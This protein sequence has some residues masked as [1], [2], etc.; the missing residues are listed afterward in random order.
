MQK[1]YSA[2]LLFALTAFRAGELLEHGQAPLSPSLR[3]CGNFIEGIVVLEPFV[4]H[5]G[6]IDDYLMSQLRRAAVA[7][8]CE[9]TLLIVRRSA[10]YLE[11][12]QPSV[13]GHTD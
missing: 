12:M 6:P 13:Y 11:A 7:L 3:P 8:Y 10:R 2:R 4:F 9:Q 5:S 1:T